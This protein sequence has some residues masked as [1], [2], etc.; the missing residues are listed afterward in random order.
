[1]H[2]KPVKV[3]FIGFAILFKIHSAHCV[4]AMSV[5]NMGLAK[6]QTRDAVVSELSPTH[7]NA[8]MSLYLHINFLS[9]HEVCIV[10][11]HQSV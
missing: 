10:R 2:F 6:F 3:S 1:M 4:I 5:N 9:L 8:L 7:P 11:V